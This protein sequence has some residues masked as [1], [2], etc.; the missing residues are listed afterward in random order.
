MQRPNKKKGGS[1]GS[2][3]P[4]DPEDNSKCRRVIRKQTKNP[5][6][7]FFKA[8]GLFSLLCIM[9]AT[10]MFSNMTKPWS[11][12]RYTI[13]MADKPEIGKQAA[14]WLIGK[15]KAAI[16]ERKRFVVAL[17]GGS[18]PSLLKSGMAEV[19]GLQASTD[20]KKWHVVWADERCVDF[21][22]DDSTFKA[23]KTFFEEVGIP[24]NQVLNIDTLALEDPAQAAKTYQ[25]GLAALNIDGA[26]REAHESNLPQLDVVMLGMG[27]DGHTASLFPGHK[28][29]LETSLSVASLTD[30]PKPP[31]SRIT[32]TVPVLNNARD[33]GFLVTGGGKAEAVKTIMSYW[34]KALAHMH[35]MSTRT[36]SR[37][38]VGA[39]FANVLVEGLGWGPAH[40][41]SLIKPKSGNLV[42]FLDKA[43]G[44]LLTLDESV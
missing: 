29:L 36:G 32:L 13:R 1:G 43:A 21:D 39:I 20:W 15:S 22:S 4:N 42:W 34:E 12:G 9:F 16:A 14:K 28:L 38:I 26:N 10:V 33:V 23:W 11:D 41:A 25:E 18:M 7:L 37:R 24:A 44:S 2:K 3:G 31:D 6:L 35:G 30:S 27:G 40:P 17:S 19:E 5:V 8:M